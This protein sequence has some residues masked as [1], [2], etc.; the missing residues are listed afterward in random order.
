M[1]RGRCGCLRA[2]CES[3]TFCFISRKR[4]PDGKLPDSPIPNL[5]P[6]LAVEILSAGNTSG[7]M[8]RKLRD[9]FSAGVRLV[10]YIDHR[11]RTA[12]VCTAADEAQTLG[13]SDV[14]DGSEV[15]PGFQLRLG[16][17]FAELEL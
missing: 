6:D 3:R 16:D 9:Y 8:A 17:L 14:L 15:L 5:V 12:T 4:F 11:S 10:W 2:K 7:E 1:K 13:E